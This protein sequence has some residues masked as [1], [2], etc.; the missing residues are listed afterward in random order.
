M[1]VRAFWFFVAAGL[2]ALSTAVAQPKNERPASSA[3][4]VV[5][6]EPL[7]DATRIEGEKRFQANCGRC[8]Q[9]PHK[10]PA[11][12]ILTVERHMRVRALVTEDDI[13]VIIKYLTQ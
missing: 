8:H 12:M 2:L 4:P 9:Y 7:D 3:E 1:S 13:R 11:R 10:L 6:N 5:R